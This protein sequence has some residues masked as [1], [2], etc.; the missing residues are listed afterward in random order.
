MLAFITK[1]TKK[2]YRENIEKNESLRFYFAHRELLKNLEREIEMSKKKKMN[3]E[4][5][6]KK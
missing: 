5:S 3:R 4:S 1:W 2:L 6:M